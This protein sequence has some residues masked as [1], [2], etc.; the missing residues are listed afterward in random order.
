M[1]RSARARRAAWDR[2]R[3]PS[4][5]RARRQRARRARPRSSSAAAATAR[6]TARSR[7]AAARA[8]RARLRPISPR[9]RPPP[10]G[11][12]ARRARRARSPARPGGDSLRQLGERRRRVASARWRASR[13]AAAISS[14]RR[15]RIADGLAH[16]LDLA[17]ER[18]DAVGERGIGRRRARRRQRGLEPARYG[19]RARRAFAASPAAGSGRA[20]SSRSCCST[21]GEPRVERPIA[22][23]AQGEHRAQWRAARHDRRRPRRRASSVRPT[24][25]ATAMAR[26]VLPPAAAEAQRRLIL[27]SLAISLAVS[28]MV[29]GAALARAGGGAAGGWSLRH[30]WS[31]LRFDAY[32][33]AGWSQRNPELSPLCDDAAL[34]RVTVTLD[35][36]GTRCAHAGYR[37]DQIEQRR[38]LRA[39]RRPG[40]RRRR[41]HER[42][43][44]LAAKAEMHEDPARDRGCRRCSA[45]SR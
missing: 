33:S 34:R 7:D 27:P 16:R 11:P 36:P 45:H 28:S 22:A 29:G 44:H 15:P 26:R 40:P 24:C 21:C 1:P 35:S 2:R 38:L 20:A 43:R 10:R 12:P 31:S 3:A 8:W 25:D 13:A 4:P 23:R 18:G 32:R 5:Q 19:R 6:R 37:S 30:S 42:L 9:A 17:L 41:P 39:R 14:L